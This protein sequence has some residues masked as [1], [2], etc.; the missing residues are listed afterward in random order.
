MGRIQRYKGID[1]LLTAYLE[2]PKDQRM[3]LVIAGSGEFSPA[4]TELLRQANSDNLI[5]I[6]RWLSDPEASSLVDAA[7]F[8]IL[9]YTSATQ[10]GVIPLASV[11][12]TPAIASD[13]GG[14]A[15]QVVDGETGMLFPAGDVS[16]LASTMQRA[17]ALSEPEYRTMS[18]AARD[19][20]NANWSWN[21]L[22][23]QLLDFFEA[24]R[25]C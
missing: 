5:V 20:A 25:G 6:N 7:R 18:Q 3:P 22:A 15:E 1:T 16:A 17:F 19:Y 13:T 14:I 23:R 4:E 11:Y 10:S 2:I 8:V 9:P 21:V 12:G 24:L